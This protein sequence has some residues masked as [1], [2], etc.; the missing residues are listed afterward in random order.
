M[1]RAIG[2]IYASFAQRLMGLAGGMPTGLSAASGSEAC[3]ARRIG[4]SSRPGAL[5]AR[6]RW[7][8]APLAPLPCFGQIRIEH[9]QGLPD[10]LLGLLDPTCRFG[11]SCPA[12]SSPLFS[13]WGDASGL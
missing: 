12:G 4:Q 11:C 5:V 3:A 13:R 6:S 7:V 9:D 2:G 10:P 1:P 8:A